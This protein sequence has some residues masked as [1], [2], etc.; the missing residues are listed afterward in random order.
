MGYSYFFAYA[1]L[2]A[3]KTKELMVCSYCQD[4]IGGKSFR[5]YGNVC[6]MSKLT[7]NPL[8]AGPSYLGK[9]V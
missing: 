8:M 5:T 3:W 1:M 4:E 7:E 6:S 9:Y 2:S